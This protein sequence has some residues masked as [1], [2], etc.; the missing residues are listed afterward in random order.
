[1][2]LSLIIHILRIEIILY[3]AQLL[4][5]LDEITFFNSLDNL[6]V[7]N[8]DNILKYGGDIQKEQFPNAQK[9]SN[10]FRNPTKQS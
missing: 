6:C 4:H 5:L 9:T 7:V 10:L 2:R 1:M 3:P 8:N